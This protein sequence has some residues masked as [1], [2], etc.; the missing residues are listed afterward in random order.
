MLKKLNS[1]DKNI[2]KNSVLSVVY[3]FASMGVS[4]ISAP[5]MLACLGE[6]KYGVWATLL[7]VVSWIYYFDL[8]IGSGLRNKL[9]AS[10]AKE[11]EDSSRKLICVSYVLVSIMS[12]VIF[13]IT[14]TVLRVVDISDVLSIQLQGEDINFVLLVAMLLACINFVASLVNNILFAV[15]NASA[16]SFFGVLGQIIFVLAMV[17]YLVTGQQMLLTLAI[18]EGLSQLL[19]NMIESIWV[20]K[21]NRKLRFSLKELDFS[22]SKGIITFGIQMF[23]MQMTALVLN[24][25]DNIIITKLFGPAEVTP[26]NFCYKYFNMINSVFYALITPLLSAYTAAYARKEISW[27]RKNLKKSWIL[28]FIFLIG[29]I[30]AGIVFKPFSNVWLKKELSYQSGLILFTGL[31]FALLMCSHVS[32]TFL[33]GIGAISETTI[34]TILQGVIN[35]PASI[36]LATKCNMGINGVILGSAVSTGLGLVVGLIKSSFVLKRLKEGQ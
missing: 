32:S 4:M 26:Y 23:A 25:T 22:Y 3:R 35:I 1:K 28:Y 12:A 6:E 33:T 36:F 24:S 34:A 2:Y 13:V 31:Y 19:K 15:Q 27:I 16:V 11:D 29:T 21:N 7:S 10:I 20:Y 14:A 30:F 18:A 8:G 5:L 9:S 17:I